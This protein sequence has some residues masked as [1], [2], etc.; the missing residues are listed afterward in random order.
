MPP[1]EYFQQVRKICDKYDVLFIADEVI[2]GLGRTGK[3]F[4]IQ[5]SEIEP[6]LITTAKGL[7]AGYGVLAAVMVSGPVCEAI[8]A[9][10]GSHT[11]GHTQCALPWIDGLHSEPTLLSVLC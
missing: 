8:A 3:N 11:Q 1:P 5:H 10:S 9:G 7:C 6:D 4:G 2:M